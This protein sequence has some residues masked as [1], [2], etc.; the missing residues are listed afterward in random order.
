M[1]CRGPEDDTF[2]RSELNKAIKNAENRVRAEME[3]KLSDK[4]RLEYQAGTLLDWLE[5]VA[6]FDHDGSDTAKL[7]SRIRSMDEVEFLSLLLNHAINHP[8]A[9]R[10]IGWWEEHKQIDALERRG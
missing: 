2:T 7:C 9:R 4:K 1:P 3:S 6:E 10:L 8:E 5:S